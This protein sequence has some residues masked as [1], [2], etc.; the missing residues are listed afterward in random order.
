[1]KDVRS[2][3]ELIQYGHFVDKEGFFSCGHLWTRRGSSVADV[4]NFW[5]KKSDF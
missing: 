4:R 5:C 1:M 3:G 2:Q